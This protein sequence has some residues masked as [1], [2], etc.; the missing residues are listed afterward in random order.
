MTKLLSIREAAEMLAIKPATIRAWLYRRRLPY[1]RCGRAIRIPA[2][3]IAR[4]I[5]RNTIAAREDR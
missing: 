3:A 4:F 2:D 5:E 1:V